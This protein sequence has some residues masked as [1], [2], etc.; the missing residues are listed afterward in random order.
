[1]IEYEY[2]SSVHK[3]NDWDQILIMNK[4]F[5]FYYLHV[6]RVLYDA[7]QWDALNINLII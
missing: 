5:F 4:Q 6:Q 1:M 2:V 7:Q 3:M